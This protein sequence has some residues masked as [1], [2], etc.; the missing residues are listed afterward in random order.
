MRGKYL[1]VANAMINVCKNDGE[2]SGCCL[3]CPIHDECMELG[4]KYIPYNMTQQQLSI[5]LE[6]IDGGRK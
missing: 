5:I 3:N 2:T 1:I 4:H 6:F